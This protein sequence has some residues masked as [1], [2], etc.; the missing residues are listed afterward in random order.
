MRASGRWWTNGLLAG[1]ST[2]RGDADRPASPCATM[3]MMLDAYLPQQVAGD[4]A[5][6]QPHGL[7]EHGQP[8][9]PLRPR[10]ADPYLRQLQLRSRGAPAQLPSHERRAA[11]R[12]RRP[13]DDR[14][15]R[16]R[17]AG[18]RN[19][20]AS[21]PSRSGSMDHLGRERPGRADR[22]SIGRSLARQLGGR[23]R[24]RSRGCARAARSRRSLSRSARLPGRSPGPGRRTWRR[25]LRGAASR[26]CGMAGPP[27]PA[28]GRP[29]PPRAR[30]PGARSC[31]DCRPR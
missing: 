5:G 18:R 25:A 1:S 28:Y 10:K 13:P 6:L 12:A 26:R 7:H 15:C 29:D 24:R 11:P 21:E 2:I 22:H 14:R 16:G 4:P 17:S 27:C 31:S 3:A 19:P 30:R 9:G 20:R 8:P 23:R